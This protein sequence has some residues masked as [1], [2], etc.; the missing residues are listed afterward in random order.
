MTRDIHKVVLLRQVPLSPA[1]VRLT[2]ALALPAGFPATGRPDEYLRLVFADPATAEV[3]P[4]R[5]GPGGR[6]I[7]PD[8]AAPARFATLTLRRFDPARGEIAIDLVLR[9]AGA[10]SRWARTAPPGTAA[11]VT[12]PVGQFAR[13]DTARWQIL[14]ADAAGLPAVARILE[15]TPPD[16]AS[17]VI[18]EVAEP[19]HRLPLP[20]HPLARIDWLHGGNGRGPSLLPD[21]LNRIPLPPGP[22]YVWAGAEQKAVRAIRRR[23]RGDLG[24]PPGQLLLVAYW[25]DRAEAWRAGWEA[26]DPQVRAGMDAAWT[27]GRDPE[28]IRDEVDAAL[29]ACGL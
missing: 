8:G 19:G 16:V 9:D 17:H 25:I 2:F 24:L 23:L 22:G 12:S 1:M 21:A 29:A 3:I 10:V 15:A 26:L 4:P 13:P 5:I 7:W 11:F 14:A 28:A 6:W 20:A 18:A 27:S